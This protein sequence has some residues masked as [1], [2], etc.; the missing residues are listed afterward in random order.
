MRAL[1]RHYASSA[2]PARPVEDWAVAYTAPIHPPPASY[3]FT[4]SLLLTMVCYPGG[5]SCG[6]ASTDTPASTWSRVR[7][8]GE[9]ETSDISPGD[10]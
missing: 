2:G 10:G 1:S 3:G 6:Y 4:T 7:Y 9:P 5:G 8:Q